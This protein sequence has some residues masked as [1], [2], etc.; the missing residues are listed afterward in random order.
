DALNVQPPARDFTPAEKALIKRMAKLVAPQQLLDILNERLFSD[1][2]PDAAPYTLAVLNAE[3]GADAGL[4]TA[5]SG[6][7]GLRK[8]LM[9]AQRSGVL[10]KVDEQL[11]D[12]FAIVYS[13]NPKQVVALKD[14]VLRTAGDLA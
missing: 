6:W 5:G 1:L 7:A 13:L 9:Q 8:L 11:I 4:Y 14:I 10:A 12:D 3:I 2:G